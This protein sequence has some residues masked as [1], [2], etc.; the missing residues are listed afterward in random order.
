MS[1][2]DHKKPNSELFAT[3]VRNARSLDVLESPKTG[4]SGK[5][6]TISTARVEEGIQTIKR[7]KTAHM[8]PRVDGPQ[9]RDG[10][11]GT[12]VDPRELPSVID[13]VGILNSDMAR[14]EQV[15]EG[16]ETT[17]LGQEPACQGPEGQHLSFEALVNTAHNTS[18]SHTDD[19]KSLDSV[20]EHDWVDLLGCDPG[21]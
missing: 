13:G 14:E 8:K 1:L 11:C 6:R 12:C 10:E 9:S 21:E 4:D 18:I 20:D 16:G 19:V 7:L 5:H 3:E 15:P 2:P 17:V